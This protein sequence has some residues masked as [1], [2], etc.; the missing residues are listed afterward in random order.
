MNVLLF[1][2]LVLYCAYTAVLL[3]IQTK[4]IWYKYIRK[5]PVRM[6]WHIL[7][8]TVWWISTISLALAHWF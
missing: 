7:P 1:I 2:F 3:W 4:L 8:K 5:L 6:H